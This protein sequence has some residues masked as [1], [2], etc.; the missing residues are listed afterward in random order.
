[1]SEMTRYWQHWCWKLA[2]GSSLVGGAIAS[3]NYQ[4]L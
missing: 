1:M 2:L 3:D 4:L